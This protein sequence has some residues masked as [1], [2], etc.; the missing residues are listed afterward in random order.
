[1]KVNWKG[2]K[3]NL[4]KMISENISYSEI[5]RRYGVTCN[6]VKKAAIKLGVVLPQKR[7]INPNETFGKGRNDVTEICKRCGK[8]FRHPAHLGVVNF[9]SDEC[10]KKYAE[11]KSIDGQQPNVKEFYNKKNI[12]DLGEQIAI[13]ELAKYG[14]QVVIPLSDNLPFDFAVF[15]NNKFYK[16]QVK[17]TSTNNGNY[18]KFRLT[19][20]NGYLHKYHKY[21]TDEIDVFILC[22]LKT[23]FLFGIKDVLG[24][25]EVRV[26]YSKTLSG[27]IRNINYASDCI[28]SVN[29]IKEIF[30]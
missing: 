21:T 6:A 23:V 18:S 29:R 3:E 4:E 30:K 14:L 8:E 28:I 2:E 15:A 24:K 11:G 1:M 19:T 5:G 12:G 9:C 25:N 22:D 27:Q 16:C 10:K 7:E 26:R 20:G 13:G 17:T